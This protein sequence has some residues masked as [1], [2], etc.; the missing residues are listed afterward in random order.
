LD[1]PVAA[2][3]SVLQALKPGGLAFFN[4]PVNSPAP[5]HIYYWGSPIEVEELVRSVGFTIVDSDVAPTT[6]YSFERAL[7]R[8]VTINSLIIAERS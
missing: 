2:L 8:K 3:T 4:V 7:R 1:R 6:G 5:D